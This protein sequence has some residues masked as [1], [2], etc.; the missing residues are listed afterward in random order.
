MG[1]RTAPEESFLQKEEEK[2]SINEMNKFYIKM[3]DQ[4]ELFR[5]DKQDFEDLHNYK[6]LEILMTNRLI[7]KEV[8]D[9]ADRLEEM[10]EV[11][12]NQS[13]LLQ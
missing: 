10:S 2:A 4:L 8:I 1:Q 12:N 11:I 9:M 3:I 6:E 7:K 13:K 5:I